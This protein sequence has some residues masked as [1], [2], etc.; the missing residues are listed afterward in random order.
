MKL[1]TL[2]LGFLFLSYLIQGNAQSNP[3]Q[4][5]KDGT[6]YFEHQKYAEALSFLQKYQRLKPADDEIKLMLGI[7]LYYANNTANA[8][9]YLQYVVESNN[10]K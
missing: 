1:K 7:C 4:L 2:L 9:K 3:R 5:K 6:R 8:R 10:D